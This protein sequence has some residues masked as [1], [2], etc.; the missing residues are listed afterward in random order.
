MDKWLK[1][2]TVRKTRD[3]EPSTSAKVSSGS[4]CANSRS[5]DHIQSCAGKSQVK[6]RKCDDDHIKFWFTC[7]GD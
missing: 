2:G 7:S 6:K 4:K 3:C 5:D 1:T